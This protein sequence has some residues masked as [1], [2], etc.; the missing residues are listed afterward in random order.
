MGSESEKR[1]ESDP[2]SQFEQYQ[3]N[4]GVRLQIEMESDPI[5]IFFAIQSVSL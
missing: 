4:N 3:I 1:M 2:N 5:T